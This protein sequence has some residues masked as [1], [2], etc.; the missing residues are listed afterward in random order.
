MEI[1]ADGDGVIDHTI[2]DTGLD[3]VFGTVTTAEGTVPLDGPAATAD[4]YAA[5]RPS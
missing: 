3:G 5:A 2:T 4:P 1:D